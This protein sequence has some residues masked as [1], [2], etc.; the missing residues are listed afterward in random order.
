MKLHAIDRETWIYKAMKMA[1]ESGARN[2]ISYVD[3]E[4]DKIYALAR[5]TSNR[6][7]EYA[8]KE[9]AKKITNQIKNYNHETDT[10]K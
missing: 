6:P 7:R 10:N 4:C 9:Y 1:Y 3:E 8:K 2:G 5:Y